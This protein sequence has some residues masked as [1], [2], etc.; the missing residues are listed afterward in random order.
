MLSEN[1]LVPVGLSKCENF[2]K[3][4]YFKNLRYDLCVRRNCVSVLE[5]VNKSFDSPLTIAT[6]DVIS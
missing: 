6:A 3:E 4:V 5:D 1:D 2:W